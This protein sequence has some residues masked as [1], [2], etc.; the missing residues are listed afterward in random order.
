VGGGRENTASGYY[1]AVDGGKSN[2]ASGN[3][4]AVGGGLQALATRHGQI[5]HAA[6]QFAAAGDAQRV[7]FVMRRTTTNATPTTLMLDGSSARLTI[8]SGKALFATVT[9]AGVINGG[10]K[11][12]HYTRKVAI[13]NVGGTTSLVGAV[14][15]L[16]TDVEDDAAYDV[17]ITADD[18]NDALQ[19]N[20]TGKASENI[21]WVAHVEGVEIAWG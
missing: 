10:S 12:A 17:A 3:Y 11:A 7:D 21:R 4:S 8:P 2:T 19:I 5:A 9:V 20:V 18:T 1:S 14:S 13:K 16:G 6:G 15:T